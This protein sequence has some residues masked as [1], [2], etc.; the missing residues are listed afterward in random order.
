MRT[1][2]LDE[3]PDDTFKLDTIVS[4]ETF[5][6]SDLMVMPLDTM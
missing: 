2:S 3:S 1:F 4:F 5:A 6:Y